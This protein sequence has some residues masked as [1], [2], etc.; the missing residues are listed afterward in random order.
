MWLKEDGIPVRGNLTN[1]YYSGE[2][3][4]LH[5]C[6]PNAKLRLALLCLSPIRVTPQLLEDAGLDED[7]NPIEFLEKNQKQVG[8]E[9]DY[10]ISYPTSLKITH[11]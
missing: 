7:F 10:G 2:G 8:V 1:L 3:Q 11:S 5:G 4:G 6:I 9:L